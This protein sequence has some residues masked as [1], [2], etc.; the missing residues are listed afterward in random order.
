MR[1]RSTHASGDAVQCL[2]QHPEQRGVATRAGSESRLGYSKSVL[3]RRA[4]S[5]LLSMR[6]EAWRPLGSKLY[7]DGFERAQP[8][9]RVARDS[10]AISPLSAR[11]K[12]VLTNATVGARHRASTSQR[13]CDPM[14]RDA[15][16]ARRARGP[17][18]GRGSVR[19]LEMRLTGG[20]QRT[21]EA[22]R[23]RA[24]ARRARQNIALDPS[25][26]GCAR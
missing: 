25:R 24:R 26:V 15:S 5:R 18:R 20:H 21:R 11:M 4:S 14:P 6:L 22:H 1:A 19:A 16:C 12:Y 10:R 7:H 2:N 23:G 9:A 8:W 3:L 13:T 17:C